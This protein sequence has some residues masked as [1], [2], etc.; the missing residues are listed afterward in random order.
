MTNAVEASSSKESHQ[1][2][3]ALVKE[4]KAAKPNADQIQRAKQLWEKLRR[5]SHVEKKERDG[6]VAELFTI[7]TGKVHDFVFKHDSVRVVQCALKY[8]N[9]QQ[10]GIIAEELKGEFRTLAQS[11]Y[12]KFLVAKL[13]TTGTDAVKNMIISEFFG[14]IRALINHPEASWILDDTY[15]QVASQKQKASM[16]REWYGPEFAI[17][18]ASPSDPAPT[19]DLSTILQENPEKRKPILQYLHDLIDHLVQKKM[20]AFTML[21]DAMLQYSLAVGA[22]TTSDAATEFLELL[23][24]DEEGELL[25][26]LAFTASGSRVVCRALALGNAKAR[27]LMLRTFKADILDLANHA[28]GSNI[29]LTAFE[30]IDD[31]KLLSQTIVNELLGLKLGTDEERYELIFQQAT[32][33]VARVPLL[34]PFAASTPKWLIRADSD[35]AKVID[36][37]RSLRAET[38]KKDPEIRRTELV[39]ALSEGGVL[40]ATIEKRADKL[41]ESSFGCQFI[42]E[43]MLGC[44]GDKSN[45]MAAVAELARGD[46]SSEGH[47]AKSSHAGKML[48][49]LAMGAKFDTSNGK[50]EHSPAKP[51]HRLGFAELLYP[52]IKDNLLQWA[53]SQN[54]FIVVNYLD[55]KG[56]KEKGDILKR[57]RKAIPELQ[58]SSGNGNKGATEILTRF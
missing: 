11:K 7:V 46:P 4:R 28:S 14:H 18:K 51:G 36:E 20:V 26:N 58:E 57:L 3:K 52:Q 24:D 47:M 44:E 25:K 22:P 53:L 35:S 42:T 37:V 15:R 17:F 27:K 45:A 19:S 21:H 9:E 48:R 49:T 34:Y 12:G 39:K 40:L 50:N 13:I 38:S 10:R 54:S 55:D 6:L 1:K 23:K 29:L 2:Q 30:V 32:N 56:F 33:I 5:K 43:V 31:T 16:L 41:V 8:A